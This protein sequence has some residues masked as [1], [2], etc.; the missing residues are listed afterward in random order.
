MLSRSVLLNV[1]KRA[2]NVLYDTG[3]KQRISEGYTRIDPIALA[4]FSDV[5][6]IAR[7][8]DKLL[9]AFLRE[10]R[11]GI[12]LNTLRPTGMVHMTCAHELGHFHLGHGTTTDEIIDYSQNAAAMEL[13]ADQFAHS[14][15]CPAWLVAGVVKMQGWDVRSL[16]QAEILY[17]LSLRLGLSY[18]ATVWS[19]VRNKQLS[20]Q[21]A[22]SLAAIAPAKLKQ[23]LVPPGT[24]LT[25]NQDVWL[26]R[27]TDKDAILE[28]RS[29]DRFV[30]ELPSHASAGFLWS[31]MQAEDVGYTLR[32]LTIDGTKAPKPPE[33][34]MV[35]AVQN[36]QYILEFDAP[37][38]I[39]MPSAPVNVALRETQPWMS[40]SHDSLSNLSLKTK[41]E[42]LKLGLSEGTRRKHV[43]EYGTK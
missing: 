11:P 42:N 14:V 20:P 36:D 25:D 28:P 30:V 43:E 33:R 7:P 8:M 27:S 41:F 1:T 9:G 18:T 37:T 21:L 35:G 22:P 13:E 23:R 39:G 10:G 2:L 4:E 16:Q 34:I 26:L 6:V 15:M 24:V 38:D 12:L 17:Q 29:Q 40:N 19:L 3:A 5:A 32:P 31:A